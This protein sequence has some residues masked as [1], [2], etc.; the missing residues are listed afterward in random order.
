MRIQVDLSIVPPEVTLI[1]PENFKEFSVDVKS[2]D[3]AWVEQ[4][5]LESLA[6][7]LAQEPDWQQGLKGML[8]YAASQGWVASNGAIR[9]HI[10]HQENVRSETA[11]ISSK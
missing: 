5:T 10:T 4:S 9:A 7:Q 3:H 6:G 2:A 1:D 8:K 11:S